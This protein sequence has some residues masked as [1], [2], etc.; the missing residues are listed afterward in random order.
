MLPMITRNRRA[1]GH[2][3]LLTVLFSL[4]C[5]LALAQTAAPGKVST[6]AG[7]NPIRTYIANGWDVLT[8]SMTR[9]DS[10]VDPKVAT[11]AVLYLPADFPAPPAVQKLQSDCKVEVEH[12]PPIHQPGQTDVR[13]INPPGL[14]YLPNAYVVP[15]GRFNE[16][17]GWDSYF[18]IV[19]LIRDGRLDL[20][21][22][23]VENFFFEVE[24]Y[25]TFLNANRTY[26]LT[27][28]QPPYL[29]SM[30]MEV[31]QAEKAAGHGDRAWLQR[32]YDYAA[33]DYQLWV[34]EPHLAGSTGLSRYFDFG[35]GPVA[36]GLQ[37]ETGYYKNVAAF[38]LTHP[39][40]ADHDLVETEPGKSNPD[41]VGFGFELQLC[42]TTQNGKKCEPFRTVSLSHDYYKGD[43]SMRESG[44]DVAFRFGPFGAQTH[45]YAAVCLNSLLY[46]TETDLATMSDTL[47]KK[48]DAARW[49]KLAEDRKARMNQLFWNSG[50]GMFFDYEFETQKQSSYTYVTTFYPMWAGLASPD[51]ARAIE[52][53]LPIFE[54]PGGL[55]MSPTE[56]GGQWDHPYGW[57]PMQLVGIEGLRRYG[58]NDDANRVAYK[59]LST[60]AE[61]FRRDGTIREKYNVV[62]RSSETT[63]TAGYHMN[64]VG[65]GWTNGVFLELLQKLPSDAV[66]RLAREQTNTAPASK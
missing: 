42:E 35:D 57:A 38:F 48:E 34:H 32:A 58:F 3:P 1:Y 47:G 66:E 61:N 62:T 33:K 60:V 18:I 49:R 26:Y 37:D 46:K 56:S 7:L 30:I 8:R 50:K 52:K 31:Y 63:V 5:S 12:L 65:F 44:F 20:A 14:L 21:K 24:H 22:G 25:G 27:R 29:S 6:P 51:Q 4:I 36:E 9:C 10:I 16:M 43:R 15:G 39:D 64:I 59:F 11:K 53:N 28:S 41:A 23:M 55:D 54:Q 13:S 17:Y 2:Y 40:R 45:H 19:G